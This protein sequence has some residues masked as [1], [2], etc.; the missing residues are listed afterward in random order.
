MIEV[1]LDVIA[2]GCLLVAAVAQLVAGRPWRRLETWADALGLLLGGALG[3]LAFAGTT[4]I[5]GVGAGLPLLTAVVLLVGVPL[6]FSGSSRSTSARALLTG[7]LC[8]VVG[9]AVQLGTG[10]PDEATVF[11]DVTLFAIATIVLAGRHPSVARL[12]QRAE[13]DDVVTTG[14]VVSL[15]A[16][17]LVSPA[18]LLMLGIHHGGQAYLL[19]VGSAALTGLALWRVAG[20]TRERELTRAALAESEAR[21]QLLLENSA[22][23]IAIVDATGVVTYM[24][25]AVQ[26]L[27]GRPPAHYVGRTAVELAHPRDRARLRDAVATAG[28]AGS[29]GAGAVD[30]DL[31]LEHSAGGTRWVEMRLS[32]R[33]DAVNISGWVVNLREVTDRKLFEEELRRQAQTDPLTGVLNRGRSPSGWPPPPPPSTRPRRRRCS[34]STSTTSRP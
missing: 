19:S 10:V 4:G 22:D 9:F 8:I 20:L 18:L 34:S 1:S 21:L 13:V 31:R 30:A 27:L 2:Y 25:P 26:T 12:G 24:S 5:D 33:V 17:L 29:P 32:G 23:V 7:G 16:T 28:R 15:G 6:A 14:R 3:V 11:D